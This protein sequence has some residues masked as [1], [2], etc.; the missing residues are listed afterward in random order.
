MAAQYTDL[1]FLKMMLKNKNTIAKRIPRA[2]K[3]QRTMYVVL[4]KKSFFSLMIVESLGTLPPAK[5]RVSVYYP[6]QHWSLGPICV[7]L[8]PVGLANI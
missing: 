3:L 8:G 2:L 4:C 6:R 7:L 1:F 5:P